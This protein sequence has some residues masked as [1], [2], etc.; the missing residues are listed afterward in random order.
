MVRKKHEAVHYHKHRAIRVILPT[1]RH[2]GFTVFQERNV[3]SVLSLTCDD[4]T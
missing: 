4:Y 3:A 2:T 1:Y